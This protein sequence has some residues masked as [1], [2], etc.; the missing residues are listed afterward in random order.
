[1]NFIKYHIKIIDFKKYNKILLIGK[2]TSKK[3]IINN[4]ILPTYNSKINRL[5]CKSFI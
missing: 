2:I 3:I 4:K 5:I 1:M